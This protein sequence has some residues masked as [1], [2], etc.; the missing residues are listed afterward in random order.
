ME[1]VDAASRYIGLRPRVAG[2][3]AKHLLELVVRGDLELIVFAVDRRLIRP[4]AEKHCGV[5][6]TVA[7]HVVVLHLAYAF[8]S[9]RLP[10]Q[11][12]A[13]APAA[14]PARHACGSRGINLRPVAPRMVIERVTML[15]APICWLAGPLFVAPEKLMPM[16]DAVPWVMLAML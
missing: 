6:E 16:G 9:Q 5:A 10:R 12:L 8:D 4:P 11:I 7:L 15:I 2:A 1:S 14:L 3:C 13:S